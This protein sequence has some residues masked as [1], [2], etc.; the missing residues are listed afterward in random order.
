MIDKSSCEGFVDI[1]LVEELSQPGHTEGLAERIRDLIGEDSSVKSRQ[2]MLNDI[3]RV[4][5]HVVMIELI[6]N[7]VS[8]EDRKFS[9]VVETVESF[10]DRIAMLD[11]DPGIRVDISDSNDLIVSVSTFFDERTCESILNSIVDF[12]N[13][14][15][16][17]ELFEAIAVGKCLYSVPHSS[18][19]ASS[20]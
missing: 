3:C 13:I 14:L 2:F 9:V 8:V 5:R 11:I 6:R 18:N 20:H 4:I 1:D 16:I 17:T 7:G 15:K 10:L 19:H 12:I